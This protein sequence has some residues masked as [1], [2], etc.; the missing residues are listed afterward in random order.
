MREPT[1]DQLGKEISAAIQSLTL[2]RGVAVE[3]IERACWNLRRD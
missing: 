3:R 1:L 2:D